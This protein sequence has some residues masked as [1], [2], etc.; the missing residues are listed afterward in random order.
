MPKRLEARLE[1][2][3]AI[4]T[5]TAE[6]EDEQVRQRRAELAA[7][8]RGLEQVTQDLRKACRERA[9]QLQSELRLELNKYS[10]DETRVPAGNPDGGQWTSEEDSGSSD[11]TGLLGNHIRRCSE[12]RLAIC[13]V[14]YRRAVRCNG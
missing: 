12:P 2:I 5:L 13:C 8:R 14:G 4:R 11:F 10:P 6:H 1:I 9:S 3:K 7:I